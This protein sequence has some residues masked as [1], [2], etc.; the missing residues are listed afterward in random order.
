MGQILYRVANIL[1]ALVTLFA[2]FNFLDNLSNG[3][4]MVP[5]PALVLAVII[6]LIGLGSRYLSMLV[7]QS[8]SGTAPKNRN[9]AT[10][11]STERPM[12]T[13]TQYAEMHI[14]RHEF[15]VTVAQ[16]I[17]TQIIGT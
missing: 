11:I 7:E 8:E 17:A 10:G 2:A 1:A 16:S 5:L 13:K 6:W 14:P 15:F 9:Q 12:H 4:P 3:E